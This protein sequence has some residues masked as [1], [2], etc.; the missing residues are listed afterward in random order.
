MKKIWY[1]IIGIAVVLLIG[2]LIAFGLGALRFSQMSA[3]PM[4]DRPR[5]VPDGFG[6]WSERGGM[7]MTTPWRLPFM[8]LLGGLLMFL[9]PVGILA[10]IVVGV[11]MLVRA[12]QK[13]SD[14]H[15]HPTALTCPNCG[16]EVQA[17]WKVCP[18][19]GEG[20]KEE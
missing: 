18:H 6:Y 8:G 19:C 20:L 12:G 10:L 9:L 1:W 17:D 13:S 5:S 15:A 11:V 16:K 4:W 7:H 2:G 3:F 14:Q